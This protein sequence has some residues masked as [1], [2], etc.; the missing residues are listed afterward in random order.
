M[1]WQERARAIRLVVF[2]VDGVMTDGGVY[3]GMVDGRPVE[4]KRFE[5]TD[6]L[7]I[8]LLQRAGLEVAIVTG[9][10]SPLVRLRAEELGVVECHEAPG[11]FKLPL[12]E[13][14]RAER[15]LA[16]REIAVLADDLADM[17][18]LRRAGL[19]AA[20]ANAV[21]DVRAV[22]HWVGQR[23]GGQGAVREFAEALLRAQGR[24]RAVVTGYLAE[25]DSAAT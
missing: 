3:W 4:L 8:H 5:I 2:D 25:R 24:W 14:L 20:V 21:P 9:R 12:V 11:G 10:A 6:G 18:L 17:P 7:G 23:R 19:A 16:W 13:R 1:T 15:G 22:A